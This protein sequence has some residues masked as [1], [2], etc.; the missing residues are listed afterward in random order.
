MKLYAITITPVSG[1]GTPL[2]G[3]TLFGHFCWQAAYD[4]ALLNEGIDHQIACY[5]TKPFAVFSSAFP[6]LD[7]AKGTA[8]LMKRPDIPFSFILPKKPDKASDMRQKKSFKKKQW[9]LVDNTFI[10][11]LKKSKFLDD[12]ELLAAASGHFSEPARRQYRKT[13]SP[14]FIKMFFQSHN[15]IN[16]LTQTTG[17]GFAPFSKE[18]RYYFPGTELAVFVLIDESATDI[19][20][21]KTGIDRIG[22]WGFGRDASIG[23]GRFKTGE[24]A[25]LALPD[26]KAGFGLY[27]LAPCVPEKERFKDIYFIPFVRFGKHGDRLACGGNPFKNPVIMADEGAVLFPHISE[28]INKPYIGRAVTDVSKTMP[29]SVVQGYSPFIPLRMEG[30]NEA[31][32]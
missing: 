23:L 18:S 16:R 32:V 4:P 12:D 7:T 26:L 22:A 14:E 25:E 5:G 8:Y 9:V 31:G 6:K 28:I 1:F 20:R 30:S 13:G 19:D 11:D 2:K 27:S 29:H 3:D 15:S 24:V 21:V 17:E 10:L